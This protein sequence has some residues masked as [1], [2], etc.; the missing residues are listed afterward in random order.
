MSILENA[1]E[2][3]NL[4]KKAGDIDLYRKIVELE[5]EIV[6]LTS[7]NLELEVKNSDL[8]RQ[9]EIKALLE[10]TAPFYYSKDDQ[11]PYCPRCWES[12][13]R[14]L[15]LS[16]VVEDFQCPQCKI[17]FFRNQNNGDWALL[18]QNPE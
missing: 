2:I 3:A 13:G 16:K 4:I 15:H 12:E 1:K 11:I 5:G 7:R 14:A 9:L 18:T 8:A 10:F 6:G 17:V